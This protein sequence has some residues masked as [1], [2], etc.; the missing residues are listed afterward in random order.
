MNFKE[1]V[2]KI[3]KKIKPGKFLTYKEVAE[4]AG[5]KN[6]QRAVGQI[7]AK[8]RNS[9]IPCHRVILSNNF[10][11]LFCKFYFKFF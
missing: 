7:L 4:K 5:N 10:F 2:F 8:N 3:V 11:L 1:K 9:K 6:A